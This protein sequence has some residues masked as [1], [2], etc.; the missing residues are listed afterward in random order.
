MDGVAE[1]SLFVMIEKIICSTSG[2]YLYIFDLGNSCVRRLNL[3]ENTVE[4][5]IQHIEAFDG[6]LSQNNNNNLYV[7]YQNISQRM[8]SNILMYNLLTRKETSI[9]SINSI[10]NSTP[11]NET[12]MEFVLTTPEKFAI[13]IRTRTPF[14]IGSKTTLDYYT[15]DHQTLEATVSPLPFV[16]IALDHDR[17]QSYI[18][19]KSSNGR[20]DQLYMTDGWDNKL[21]VLSGSILALL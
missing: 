15:V 5:L 4:T 11:V 8:K 21:K 13:Q 6:M 2:Q 10:V 7:I 12:T 16:T 19:K 3:I 20:D 1:T 18:F 14:V 9:D 17:S